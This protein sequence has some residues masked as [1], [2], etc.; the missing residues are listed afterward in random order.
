MTCSDKPSCES[1]NVLLLYSER[2]SLLPWLIAALQLN[3][4]NQSAGLTE[5]KLWDSAAKA[6][7][8]QGINKSQSHA[9]FPS[10]QR[11]LKYI[12]AQ[13]KEE[14][15]YDTL[16]GRRRMLRMQRH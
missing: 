2:V 9:H 15:W 11:Y 1:N 7:G 12:S 13:W 10:Q 8:F 4:R 16:C 6:L 3:E 5:A 14:T